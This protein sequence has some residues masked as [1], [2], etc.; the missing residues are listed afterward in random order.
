MGA[1]AR[2]ALHPLAPAAVH[3]RQL[4]PPQPHLQTRELQRYLHW[5]NAN[6]RHPYVLTAQRKELAHIRSE[7]GIRWDGR[8]AAVA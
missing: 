3:P 6:A 7:K 4:P 2:P 1:Q 5:R 8:L